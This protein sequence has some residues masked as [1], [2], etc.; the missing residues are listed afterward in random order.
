MR[1]RKVLESCM[2]ITGAV[3]THAEKDLAS[4]GV[5]QGHKFPRE[6]R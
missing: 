5:G 4:D 1:A 2:P 6:R 3:I